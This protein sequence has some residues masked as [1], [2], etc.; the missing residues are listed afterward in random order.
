ML[1]YILFPR[2]LLASQLSETEAC[3]QSAAGESPMYGSLAVLRTLYSRV[4][5]W[6]S[7]WEEITRDIIA[8]G[9]NIWSVVSCV[10]VSDSPEG[11]LPSD[12]TRITAG[13]N[14]TKLTREILCTI[15]SDVIVKDVF[16]EQIAVQIMDELVDSLLGCSTPAVS[17]E[18]NADMEKIEQDLGEMT[19][20]DETED[21]EED[22]TELSES[23]D[24]KVRA[25]S[26][27][28]L[29]LCSWRCV[30]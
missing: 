11:H 4:T 14:P 18:S 28:M 27:Q 29:L 21:D 12:H 26:S 25:V 9:Y 23:A 22:L 30:K 6:D 20:K 10:V 13:N 16:P 7:Q 5:V 17:I 8:L 3:L 2:D 24:S 15:T 1:L 19:V